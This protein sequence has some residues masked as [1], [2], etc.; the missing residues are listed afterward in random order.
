MEA[1]GKVLHLVRIREQKH[2][3]SYAGC[4]WQ[5]VKV[6]RHG[7]GRVVS[8]LGQKLSEGRQKVSPDVSDDGST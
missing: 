1:E 6:G 3:E 7:R 8:G 2:A 4:L 5:L